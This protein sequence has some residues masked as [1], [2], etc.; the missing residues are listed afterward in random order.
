MSGFSALFCWAL[1]FL[2]KLRDYN[3][4]HWPTAVGIAM[5]E[6]MLARESAY[7]S[8][9]WGSL[10]PFTKF[11]LSSV[12]IENVSIS[13]VEIENVSIFQ[14]SF[15]IMII[16]IFFDKLQVFK[17]FFFKTAERLDFKRLPA[18]L[19]YR[20][21]HWSPSCD[22]RRTPETSLSGKIT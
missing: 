14:S 18:V 7:F 19:H 8:W 9:T 21:N 13:S 3:F 1:L 12:E 15:I 5:V 6:M 17:P 2:E 22:M 10:F 20:T 4:C 16:I 11:H